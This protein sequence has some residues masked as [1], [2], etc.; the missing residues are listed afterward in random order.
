MISIISVEEF[1]AED[2]EGYFSVSFGF[3]SE[4][5]NDDVLFIVCG[6]EYENN[7]QINNQ[8]KL[9]FE[10][11]D[12]VYSGYN[13]EESILV[14]DKFIDI[15]FTIGGYTQLQFPTKQI[16]FDFSSAK[17]DF[18]SIRNT[19][20]KMSQLEWIKVISFEN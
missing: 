7:F 8:N 15:A 2:V 18:S 4:I 14:K 20:E 9:Y 16:R 13:L 19:F 6:K 12:Q 17:G 10:R 5:S 11:F 3:E 1:L